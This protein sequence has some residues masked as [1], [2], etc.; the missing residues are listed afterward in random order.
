[1]IFCSLFVKDIEMKKAQLKRHCFDRKIQK[2]FFDVETIIPKYFPHP[3]R[4]NKL[5]TVNI[6]LH[7]EVL[8]KECT[9][10]CMLKIRKS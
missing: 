9:Y 5:D 2:K 4:N 1:M 7:V 6:C 3:S 10:T 8:K